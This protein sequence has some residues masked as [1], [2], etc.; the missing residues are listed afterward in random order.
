MTYNSNDHVRLPF[1]FDTGASKSTISE[2]FYQRFPY[3]VEINGK[4][5][6]RTFEG[7]GGKKEFEGFDIDN[8]NFRVSNKTLKLNNVFVFKEPFLPNGNSYYGNIGQDAIQQFERV[9][10]DF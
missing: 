9:T 3:D 10:I 2:N 6:K 5:N 7:V 1:T 8:V 4:K